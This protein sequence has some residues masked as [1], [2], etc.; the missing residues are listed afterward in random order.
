MREKI[1]KRHTLTKT[2]LA[3]AI[4][5]AVSMGSAI[6]V[7]AATGTSPAISSVKT[8]GKETVETTRKLLA[9]R[10]Q[11]VEHEALMAI[12]GTQNALMALHKNDTKQAMAFLQ[13]VSGKL[14]ILLAKYPGLT[15]IPASIEANVYDF[16]NDTKQVEKIIDAADDLL[17]DHRVQDA[18]QILDQLV[19]EIRISTISIPLGTYPGAIRDAVKLIGQGETKEAEEVLY[20]V[21]NTLVGVTEIMPLPVL[22]AETQLTA[23]SELEHKSDLSKEASRTEILLLTDSAKD[24]LKLAEI[25]G[26]GT[27]D[28]Y[29]ELYNAI[30]DIKDVI[31]TEKSAAAWD[32]IKTSLATLKNKIMHPGK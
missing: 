24:K 9:E 13:D 25:L 1:M 11:K 21:L 27:K 8:P 4:A 29:K 5:L 12:T 17:E 3:M 15:L 14:D 20:N 32:K 10:H 18:R 16:D 2:T 22:R 28:D 30:D 7:F 23:A 26:Y 19:S 31:H 6:P